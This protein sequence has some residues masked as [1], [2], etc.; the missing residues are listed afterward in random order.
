VDERPSG[1]DENWNP[2]DAWKKYVAANDDFG[3]ADLSS[4]ADSDNEAIAGAPR[5]YMAVDSGKLSEDAELAAQMQYLTKMYEMDS[6]A[7]Q[8][9]QSPG[10][11]RETVSGA[12]EKVE[13]EDG[14]DA[15]KER[16]IAVKTAH[17][18]AAGVCA[19]LSSFVYVTRPVLSVAAPASGAAFG[20]GMYA[21]VG[22]LTTL[23]QRVFSPA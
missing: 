1:D 11:T 7:A 13:Q 9:S 17:V 19:S 8:D 22:L 14:S 2:D 4:G 21:V 20:L 12:V 5:Q 15:G 16:S 23:G 3:F 6:S 10:T 18:V